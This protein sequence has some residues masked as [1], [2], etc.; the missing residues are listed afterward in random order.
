MVERVDKVEGQMMSIRS[1]QKME[2]YLAVNYKSNEL[3]TKILTEVDRKMTRW[4]HV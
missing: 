4:K 2:A 3:K 1:T